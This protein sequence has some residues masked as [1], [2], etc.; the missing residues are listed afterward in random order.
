MR[1]RWIHGGGSAPGCFGA[2]IFD[3]TAS[4]C[5]RKLNGIASAEMNL[6]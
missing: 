2:G 4:G 6:G 1:L 3:I 5:C